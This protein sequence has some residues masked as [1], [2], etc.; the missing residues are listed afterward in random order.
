MSRLILTL[1]GNNNTRGFFAQYNKKERAIIA[2]KTF[3]WSVNYYAQL[4]LFDEI[5]CFCDDDYMV[6]HP[7][8]TMRTM[9]R[10]TPADGKYFLRLNDTM[11]F[12]TA[13]GDRRHW[14]RDD[15]YLLATH[16]DAFFSRERLHKMIALSRI[17]PMVA[18]VNR[19]R[20]NCIPVALDG[21]EVPWW[22]DQCM[23]A[24]VGW[25]R[26]YD[27]RFS[28]NP[29]FREVQDHYLKTAGCP[30]AIKGQKFVPL[31]HPSQEFPSQGK[32][33]SFDGYQ[34]ASLKIAMYIRQG[35]MP[36]SHIC[37]L[38]DGNHCDR[39]FAHLKTFFAQSPTSFKGIANNLIVNTVI[40]GRPPEKERI[41]EHDD[42]EYMQNVRQHLLEL[43]GTCVWYDIWDSEE[44]ER[45]ASL[46]D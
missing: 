26:K 18:A 46:L 9:I 39:E 12:A 1:A 27:L 38:G 37:N 21:K 35:I 28:W 13:E 23:I 20:H 32:G 30:I 5:I 4:N 40:L 43:V 25:L 24:H 45:F 14:L 8:S 33:L 10:Q 16:M 6:A 29:C 19:Y 22:A 17:Y 41:R 7:K 42:K 34:E 36:A 44:R 11:L 31:D 2:Q 15:D 3:N